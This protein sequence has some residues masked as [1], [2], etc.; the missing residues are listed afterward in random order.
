[1][2][3]REINTR[4]VLDVIR[5]GKI[6]RGPHRDGLGDW[7][8]NIWKRSAAGQ[9]VEVVLALCEDERGNTLTVITV[10]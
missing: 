6:R 4:Q 9:R 3:E 1:M 8:M 5:Q 10:I 7:R 2:I